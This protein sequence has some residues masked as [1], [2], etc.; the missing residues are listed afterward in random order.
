V[1]CRVHSPTICAIVERTRKDFGMQYAEHPTF[2]PGVVLAV[3]E[4]DER[5]YSGNELHGGHDPTTV[6]S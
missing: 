4:A 1:V 5:L 6:F 3:A 2:W